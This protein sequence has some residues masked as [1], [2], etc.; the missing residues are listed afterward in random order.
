MWDVLNLGDE[1][2]DLSMSILL[3]LVVSLVQFHL[4][5][6]RLDSVDLPQAWDDRP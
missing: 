4:P 3:I 5:V 2:L 1:R 6:Q